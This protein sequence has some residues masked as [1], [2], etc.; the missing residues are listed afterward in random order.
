MQM[1]LREI[2]SFYRSPANIFFTMVFPVILV[3]LLGTMLENIETSEYAVGTL[4]AGYVIDTGDIY[5]VGLVPFF[6]SMN[7]SD[8]ISFK[9][10]S[11]KE[12]AIEKVKSGEICSAVIFSG[13]PMTTEIYGG[14]DETKGRAIKA[15]IDGYLTTAGAYGAII[16]ED[17]MSAMTVSIPDKNYVEQ[18]ECG[19]SR[20]MIDYYAVSMVV[21]I[22]FIGGLIST[23][24]NVYDDRKGNTLTR[25]FV[26]P[27]NRTAAFIQMI[28]GNMPYAFLQVI[29]TMIASVLLFD[30]K[31]CMDFKGNIMLFVMMFCVSMTLIALSTIFGLLLKNVNPFAITFPVTWIMLFLSGSFAKSVHIDGFSEYLP[32]YILQNAAFDLTLFGRYE[33]SV[34]LTIISVI[35]FAIFLV[36]GTLLFNRRGEKA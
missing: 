13:N 35:L 22:M 16:S 29:V 6:D 11:S 1:I 2:R 34:R 26:S 25:I 17:P 18:K 4:E 30:A 32:P 21:M 23:A 15:V 8:D 20:S 14:S 3:Y 36:I 28:I 24:G 33:S 9:E 31:Y 12:E 27:K 7:E 10:Y 5:A 19:I